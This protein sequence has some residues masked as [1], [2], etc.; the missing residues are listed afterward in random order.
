MIILFTYD[1][2]YLILTKNDNN[3]KKYYINILV[4]QC[5]LHKSFS[6]RCDK[7]KYEENDDSVLR[8]IEFYKYCSKVI[9]FKKG[10]PKIIKKKGK[11]SL[12]FL[13]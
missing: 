2:I 12:Q 10:V 7:N 8:Y 5:I 1:R 4:E 9:E 11:N 6:C 3:F 13:I